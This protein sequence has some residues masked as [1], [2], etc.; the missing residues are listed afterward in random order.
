MA[1]TRPIMLDSL[2]PVDHRGLHEAVLTQLLVAIRRGQLGPGERLRE[3][4]I[5]E[6]LGLSRGTVREAIRRL[7]QEGLVVSQPHRGA[8]IAKVGVEEA[9]EIYSLRRVLEAFAVRLAIPNLDEAALAELSETVEAMVDAA[10]SG[11]RNEHLR[12][13]LKFHEQICVRA[14]HR[15]LHRVWSGLAL[16][17]WLVSFGL[18][19]DTA[20]DRS[21]RARAHFALVDLLRRGDADRA[22]EWIERHIDARKRQVIEQFAGLAEG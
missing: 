2:E 4:E 14:R 3:A 21:A 9:E 8:Y 12:I 20:D 1:T 7:E 18:R 5:A 16:K 22:V 13:D 6:R 19:D 17:L 10:R 11:D 15:Y